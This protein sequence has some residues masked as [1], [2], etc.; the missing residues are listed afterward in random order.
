MSIEE[1]INKINSE[2]QEERKSGLEN[3]EEISENNISIF[4]SNILQITG[5]FRSV[6]DEMT[7]L[8]ISSIFRDVNYTTQDHFKD[9]LG[10]LDYLVDNFPMDKDD[11][12]GSSVAA[13][14]SQTLRTSLTNNKSN[15]Q[16]AL[17]VLLK[18]LKKS[19]FVKNIAYGYISPYSMQS[20]KVLAPHTELIF[21]LVRGG[22]T[23]II[24][25]LMNLYNHRSEVFE[26]PNNLNMM[27]DLCKNPQWGSLA[28]NIIWEISKKRPE[29]ISP[30]TESL[31]EGLQSPMTASSVAIIFI[32]VARESPEAVEPYISEIR[33]AGENISHLGY[34]ISNILG[35]VG[36]KSK[37][38]A[39]EILPMLVEYLE[40]SDQNVLVQV[41]M[42]IKNLGELD[43]ELLDP[44][45]EKIQSFSDD[46]QQYVRDQAKSIID[47]YEGRD[48]SSLMANFE[49]LNKEIKDSISSMDDLK[50]YVD[51]HV[52]ELKEFMAEVVKKLPIPRAFSSEGRLRKTIKLHFVCGCGDDR[53]LFPKDRPFFTE[54]KEINKWIKVAL[55]TVKLG[56]AVVEGIGGGVVQSVQEM[57]QTATGKE[58]AEFLAIV[59][60]PF[61]TSYEQDYLIDRLRNARYFDFFNYNSQSATWCCMM[62]QPP[63]PT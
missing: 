15:F 60:E 51:D 47:Y 8:R 31:H 27:V 24:S 34:Q 46:P 42:Q 44:Y 41:L 37:E 39:Q 30:Y 52:A 28:L 2:N 7:L 22:Y 6:K 43:R 62:C 5:L 19:S 25:P 26:K 54:T 36:R 23:E 45:I 49:D 59:N 33:E 17:P 10:V 55:S 57:Y 35:L 14:L 63:T 53:C 20:P 61:L 38:K 56:V 29:L 32:E 16:I 9:I 11:G 12:I 13:N 40:E 50:N 18:Y 3:L 1:V 48:L 4:E 58:D 21:D